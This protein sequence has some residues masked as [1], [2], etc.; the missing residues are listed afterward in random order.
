[1]APTIAEVCCAVLLAL[2][3]ACTGTDDT[4]ATCDSGPDVTWPNFADGFFATY[5]R[6]CHSASAVDRRDAPPT[7]NFD[8]AAEVRDLEERV[9]V[10]VIEEGTMP[11]GG[12]V[13]EDDLLLLQRYLDC[14]I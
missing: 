10:R 14:S 11:A 1:M 6:S 9:R 13:T 8:T 3:I 7:V 12:G 4:A 2:L 5:C